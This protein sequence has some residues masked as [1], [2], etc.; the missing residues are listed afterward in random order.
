MTHTKLHLQHHRGIM[1]LL[2]LMKWVVVVMLGIWVIWNLHFLQQTRSSTLHMVI[3]KRYKY[4]TPFII[5]A[6][7]GGRGGR[8]IGRRLNLYGHSLA[9]VCNFTCGLMGQSWVFGTS[10]GLRKLAYGWIIRGKGN[11]RLRA[12]CMEKKVFFSFI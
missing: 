3:L 11:K 10:P 12:F 2:E 5:Q 4:C 6:K 9:R 7:G 1:K 8:G